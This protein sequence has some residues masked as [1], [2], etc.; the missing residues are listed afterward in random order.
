MI[1]Y[2]LPEDSYVSLRLTT[3]DGRQ[4]S[5]IDHEF[6]SKGEYNLQLDLDQALPGSSV[7]GMFMVSLQTP[8]GSITRKLLRVE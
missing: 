2:S 8:G 7:C 3:V 6:L 4:V 1:S 5:L